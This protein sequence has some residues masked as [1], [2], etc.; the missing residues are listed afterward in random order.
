MST[1]KGGRGSGRIIKIPHVVEEF[2]RESLT[3]L[4]EHL[5]D[6]DATVAALDKFTAQR[7]RH[8]SFVRCDNGP[9]PTAN[10]LWDWCRF[11]GP[12]TSYIEPDSPWEYP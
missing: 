7:R 1:T 11:T 2:T 3:D 9:E 6:A 12:G 10:A 8:P 5:I 4:V